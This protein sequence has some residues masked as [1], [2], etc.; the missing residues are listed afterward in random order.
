MLV[1]YARGMPFL[2]TRYG[3]Y[4]F[5]ISAGVWYLKISKT[6]NRPGGAGFDR[7]RSA[8]SESKRRQPWYS[9]TTPAF[10]CSTARPSS[11]RRR[12]SASIGK[13][14]GRARSPTASSR[15]TTYKVKAD[16]P[17]KLA[18][19][20][21]Y[22]RDQL[23]TVGAI[24]AMVVLC[25]GFKFDTGLTAF[26]FAAILV[27]L[28]AADEKKAIKGIPWGT[29]IFICGVGT[30]I[31]V[32]NK[33]GGIS[34]ISD[35]LTGLMGP[36][37]ATPILAATSGIL[38]WVSSTTGVVMPALFPICSEVVTKF[39]PSVNY[40]ELI[41]AVT[42][43][44]FAAAISPLSAGGAIIMSSI[45]ASKETTNEENNK[46]FKNLFLLSVANVGINVLM[47]ALRVFTLGGIFY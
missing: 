46:M 12:P 17:L 8:D 24:V 25:I 36:K 9:F 26:V 45:S 33:L 44:S 41:A 18:D 31:N 13:P 30:L 15:H 37:T 28:G 2:N 43:T 29:L 47:A 3:S 35:F 23:L 7:F 32:I 39:A 6:E 5:Q 40:M 34:L 19:I 20:P 10:I 4:E 22:N 14:P 21:K 16:N 38:S 27:L 11:P 42:A 1:Q